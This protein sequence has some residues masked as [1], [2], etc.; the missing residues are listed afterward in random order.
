MPTSTSGVLPKD[1]REPVVV[2]RAEQ[3][4]GR[5][6]LLV[7]LAVGGMAN[8]YLARY[9]GPD[10]FEK[11]VAI[12]RIHEALADDQDFVA[13]FTDEARL[14][15]RINHPNVVQVLE[16]GNV[17][18]AYFIAMEYVEGDS[19]AQLIKRSPIPYPMC[20]RIVS[21]A[22]RGLHAAHELRDHH[23]N[24]LH[25]V[26]RDVSPQNVLLSYDGAVKVVD[27][28]VA[29]ART[30]LSAT[31]V[32]RVKGKFSYMAP[33]Q[34]LPS[35]FG[36]VDRRADVFALGI[37]LFE[38]ITRRRLF[39]GEDHEETI[40]QVLNRS[41][42]PP[43]VYADDCPEE[44]SS[45]CLRALERE[46]DRRYQTA[47]KLHLALEGY[48]A[49]CGESVLPGTIAQIMHEV[50]A[51]QMEQKANMVRECLEAIPSADQS[52]SEISTLSAATAEVVRPP[53]RGAWR[54]TIGVASVAVIVLAI[55]LFALSRPEPPPPKAAT[56]APAPAP[57]VQPAPITIHIDVKPPGARL[58]FDGQAVA[59]PYDARLVPVNREVEVVASAKGY[60]SQ[61][62]KVSLEEGRR[63]T[64]ALE[65]APQAEPDAAA[66]AK[67]SS[68]RR[69]RRPW[70]RRRPPRAKRPKPKSKV[71]EKL[72]TNPYER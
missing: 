52:Y 61:S 69:P 15:A 38:A 26:H 70:R 58:V 34:L 2:P 23:G 27:F 32:G 51:E 40:D 13:M 54:L 53:R 42:P 10:G 66:P 12:K 46:K 63:W 44:L 56:P 41:I 18:S 14:A 60:L 4:F 19:M 43:S 24:A 16:L 71:I 67:V 62:F 21:E 35:R 48:L 25:V 50:F 45:I 55:V 39:K 64:L 30:N 17:S 5:Y 59:N 22:A 29:K 33:E 28:G 11:L 3:R 68:R 8:L 9:V 1:A 6:T 31:Q 7:R 20:A 65:R 37:L 57:D 36:P 47:E 72:F 49:E